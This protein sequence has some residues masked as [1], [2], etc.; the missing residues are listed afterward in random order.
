MAVVWT[1]ESCSAF[2]RHSYLCPFLVKSAQKPA[3]I[4][5][6]FAFIISSLHA[7]ILIALIDSLRRED[8]PRRKSAHRIDQERENYIE[9]I[10]FPITSLNCHLRRIS[11]LPLLPVDL[12]CLCEEV[13]IHLVITFWT[14]IIKR[15]VRKARDKCQRL[16]RMYSRMVII[17]WCTFWHSGTLN[18]LARWNWSANGGGV[19]RLQKRVMFGWSVQLLSSAPTMAMDW[20]LELCKSRRYLLLIYGEQK[21]CDHIPN[22]PLKCHLTL[23]H[24]LLYIKY[25]CHK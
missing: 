2:P 24:S 17:W 20:R 10:N 22:I 21:I 13:P 15:W 1:S 18:P 16:S 3:T 14:G 9:F 23:L 11:F 5:R 8:V 7:V 6:P 25:F 4:P 19:T 12:V